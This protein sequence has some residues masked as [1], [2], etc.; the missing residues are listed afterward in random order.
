MGDRH[1]LGDCQTEAGSASRAALE[2]FE[3]P[4]PVGLRHTW[5]VVVDGDRVPRRPSPRHDAAAPSTG[6]TVHQRV[7]NDVG[8]G[9][10]HTVSPGDD[11]GRRSRLDLDRR[12]GCSSALVGDGGVGD[13]GQINLAEP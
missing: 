2:P 10:A 8:D 1:L 3:H 12:V 13:I 4:F 5:P 6:R 9:Q 7:A 11:R